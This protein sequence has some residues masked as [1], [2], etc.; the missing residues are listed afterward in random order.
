MASAPTSD[1]EKEYAEGTT[2]DLEPTTQNM[3][4][5]KLQ[6]KRKTSLDSLW[7]G[8]PKTLCV[9]SSIATMNISEGQVHQSVSH[10]MSRFGSNMSHPGTPGGPLKFRP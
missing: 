9:F 7:E 8:A 3:A 6:K 5:K 10:E 4:I 1:S 2:A